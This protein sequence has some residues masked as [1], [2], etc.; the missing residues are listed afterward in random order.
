MQKPKRRDLKREHAWGDTKAAVRAY[1][2]NPCAATEQAV[3][4]AL[5]KVRALPPCAPK[6]QARSKPKQGE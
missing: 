5:G 6:A 4:A 3:S 1:S 2:H